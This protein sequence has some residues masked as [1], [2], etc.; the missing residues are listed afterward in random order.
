M[1]TY[2]ETTVKA[3][4][5]RK[6][7]VVDADGQRVGRLASR[8]AFMLRGKNNPKFTSHLDTGDFVVV[9]NADKVRFTGKKLETKQY[10]QHTGFIGNVKSVS[11]AELLKKKPED[12]VRNAVQGMLPKTS[13]GRKQLLKLKIYS[14]SKHPHQAQFTGQSRQSS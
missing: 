5:E 9:I 6:W 7:F 14:G 11:A 1:K 3:E 10:K 2:F 12:I 4:L 13:L 8:I